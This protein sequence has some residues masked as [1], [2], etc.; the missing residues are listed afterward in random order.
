MITQSSF[1]E[2]VHGTTNQ[3]GEQVFII[4]LCIGN[5][6]HKKIIPNFRGN[7]KN[8]AET[9]HK[10]SSIVRSFKKITESP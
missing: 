10:N 9:L 4:K 7:E 8:I 5:K 3:K 6:K 1:R 2:T